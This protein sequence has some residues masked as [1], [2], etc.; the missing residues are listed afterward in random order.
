MVRGEPLAWICGTAEIDGLRLRIDPGVYVPRCWQSP[1]LAARATS[2]LAPGG[3]AVDL[4]TGAG[5]IAALLQRADPRARVLATEADPR[6]VACARSNGVEVLAGDLFKPLSAALA[7]AVDVITA[8]AP[9]VPTGSLP[10]LPRDTLAHEPIGALH[11]G[12][13]G[14]ATILRIVLAA[15]TWLRRGASLVLEHGPDQEAAVAELLAAAGF[16]DAER[17]VDPDGDC[18]GTSDQRTPR[19][20]RHISATF[21]PQGG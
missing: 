16:V 4:C 2:L 19:P 21:G 14:L 7:G 6:A 10:L 5:T 9:Y 3:T 11:G 12:R 1:A 15:P 8:V 17:I 13:D 20:G 18:C